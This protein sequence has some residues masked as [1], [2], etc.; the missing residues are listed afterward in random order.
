MSWK[1]GYRS[2]YYDGAPEP[3]GFQPSPANLSS[4]LE[5]NRRQ[6]SSWS[7]A[8]AGSPPT[9]SRAE[10]SAGPTPG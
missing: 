3:A 5:A 8:S 1:T 10:R 7:S 4:P 9:T 2:I 6:T